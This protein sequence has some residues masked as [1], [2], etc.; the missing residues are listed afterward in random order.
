MQKSFTLI[1]SLIVIAIIGILSTIILPS[2]FSAKQNLA[3]YRAANK[4][5]QDIRSIQE[6]AMSVQ[7]HSTCTH[8]DYKYGYGIHLKENEPLKYILFTDCNGNENFDSGQDE[9][10]EE[11]YFEN[12]IEISEL[13]SPNLN[14]IFTPPDPSVNID[15]AFISIVND[16]G[17]NKTINV[18]SIGLIDID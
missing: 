5:T 6:K 3:F 8:A 9:M 14:I 4:L 18:N 12:G 10:M 17:Q 2:Y 16:N 7:E 13:S 1:E 11:I 15:T